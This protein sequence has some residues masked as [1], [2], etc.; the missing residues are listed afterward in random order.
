M[1]SILFYVKRSRQ[2]PQHASTVKVL[3]YSTRWVDNVLLKV[4]KLALSLYGLQNNIKGLS[5][6]E[7][8]NTDPYRGF[9][10]I[11]ND[12]PQRFTEYLSSAYIA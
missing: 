8:F 1:K 3:K 6:F 12:Q 5:S 4:R 9:N 7:K 11:N 10:R 2:D